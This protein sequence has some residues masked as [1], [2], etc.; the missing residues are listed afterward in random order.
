MAIYQKHILLYCINASHLFVF[1]ISQVNN[2]LLIINKWQL[3]H[4]LLSRTDNFRNEHIKLTVIWWYWHLY[5]KWHHFILLGTYCSCQSDRQLVM[6]RIYILVVI[7]SIRIISSNRDK[8]T[9]ITRRHWEFAIRLTGC[10]NSLH[11]VCA[12]DIKYIWVLNCSKEVSI[13][14]CQYM[15]QLILWLKVIRY[16]LYSNFASMRIVVTL[17]DPCTHRNILS[18]C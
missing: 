18:I 3:I 6:C 13:L 14:F 7:D 17:L 8:R 9:V 1:Q 12:L 5:P 10:H 11:L 16:Y 2:H 4:C 15:K